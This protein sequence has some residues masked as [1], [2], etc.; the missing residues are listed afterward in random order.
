MNDVDGQIE[1]TQLDVVLRHYGKAEPQNSSGEHRMQ[2]VFSDDCADSTY[3]QLAVNQNSPARVI[4]CH[5]C[6]VRGNLL[7]L[8]HGLETNRPPTGPKLRGDEFKT[9]FRKL[10]EINGTGD[11]PPS[12]P[13]PAPASA[14]HREPGKRNQPLR[15]HEKEAA[16]S[17]EDLYE[18]LVTDPSHMS[19]N[20]GAYFRHRENWL[21]PEVAAKWRMGYI[22][23]NG[24]SLFK[25][26]IVYAHHNEA[27]DIISYSGRDVAFDEKWQKWIRD[28]RPEGKRPAKHKYVSGYHRGLELYGQMGRRLQDKRLVESLNERGLIIVE[29][30]NEVI[31]LDCL[32]VAAVGL[33]S[34]K[35]T[36]EQIAKLVRFAMQ[37]ANGRVVLMGDND[38]EGKSGFNDLSWKLMEHGLSVR[39]GWS[40]TMYDGDFAGMQPEDITAEQWSRIDA[41]LSTT[42]G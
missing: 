31:R 9:A 13:S 21:T 37:Q 23:K 30:A 34:N 6:G 18:D 36:D 10:L 35:A 24:R 29:G 4:Y 16:R 26:W 14:E 1:R 28:G 2:C 11:A 12:P 41:L 8:I 3:G 19:P 15:T 32:G 17:L 22:P 20:A 27:G 39:L 38:E 42:S 40:S 7:T 25:N 33:C 5:S